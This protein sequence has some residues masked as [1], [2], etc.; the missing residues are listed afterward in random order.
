[1]SLHVTPHVTPCHTCH[2]LLVCPADQVTSSRHATPHHTLLVLPAAQ[3]YEMRAVAPEELSKFKLDRSA[4]W[5]GC[6]LDVPHSATILDFVFSD[7]DQKLWDN[8]GNKDFHTKI[9]GGW[10]AGR[11]GRVGD[12]GTGAGGR[13]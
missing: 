9:R 7:R 4:S 5:F 10:G 6:W 12:R 1:M 8:N 3:V 11:Q 13:R 2:T